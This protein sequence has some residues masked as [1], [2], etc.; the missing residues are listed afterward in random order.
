MAFVNDDDLIRHR[1]L[2]EHHMLHLQSAHQYLVDRADE[3]IG[4]R[5]PFLRPQSQSE[6]TVSGGT[7][8]CFPELLRPSSS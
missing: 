8:I 4:E 1:K 7:S 5:A 3:E 2:A 6:T